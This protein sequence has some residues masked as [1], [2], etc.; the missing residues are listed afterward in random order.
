[1]L[2]SLRNIVRH[3]AAGTDTPAGRHSL[4]LAVVALLL[5]IGRA[6]HSLTQDELAA[7]LRAAAAV[8]DITEDESN[9]L[10]GEAASAVEAAVSGRRW[11][12]RQQRRRGIYLSRGGR[13][14]SAVSRG[15]VTLRAR[16]RALATGAGAGTA[17]AP[18]S[19]R[20]YSHFLAAVSP[21]PS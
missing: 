16:A 11:W 18:A 13:V 21:S 1:M 14:C 17:G 10:L 9:G 4:Q 3:L 7:V 8:F 5:E 20:S 2:K 6:D 12:R 15:G 19:R